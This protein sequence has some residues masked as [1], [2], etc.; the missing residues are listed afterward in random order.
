MLGLRLTPS[1]VGARRRKLIVSAPPGPSLGPELITSNA[2]L[3]AGLPNDCTLSGAWAR[4]NTGG[5]PWHFHNVTGDGQ[6]YVTFAPSALGAKTYRLSFDYLE[7]VGQINIVQANFSGA[8]VPI[9]APIIGRNS[10]DIT[11]TSAAK[12]IQL[13]G[14]AAYR[15]TNFSIR[16]VLP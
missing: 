9:E 8:F 15:V 4:V 5:F 6:S 7:D 1:V 13:Q 3:V 11:L 16:E 12:N 10:V 2:D 14:G